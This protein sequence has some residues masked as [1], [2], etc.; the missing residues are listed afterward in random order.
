MVGVAKPPSVKDIPQIDLDPFVNHLKL[1]RDRW[2]HF[3]YS[4]FEEELVQCK[5]NACCPQFVFFKINQP[6]KTFFYVDEDKQPN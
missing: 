2:R 4:L 1:Y 6:G 5:L 3:F